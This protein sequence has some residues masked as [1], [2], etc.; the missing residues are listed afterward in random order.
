MIKGPWRSELIKRSFR[1]G[2]IQ[3]CLAW[4]RAANPRQLMF[5]AMLRVARTK[6]P[7]S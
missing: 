4:S 7:R 6:F 1:A 2:E 3:H 5:G